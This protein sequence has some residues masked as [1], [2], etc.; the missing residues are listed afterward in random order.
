[1]IIINSLIEQKL[2]K[3]NMMGIEVIGYNDWGI[4]IRDGQKYILYNVYNNSSY[5]AECRN[6]QG[7]APVIHSHFIILYNMVPFK[8]SN[9][10]RMEKKPALFTKYTSKDLLQR[11]SIL[12]SLRELR[13]PTYELI[14][15]RNPDFKSKTIIN[16]K[17]KKLRITDQS[18]F[19]YS[20]G[21]LIRALDGKYYY[22]D[23]YGSASVPKGY[24]IAI[25]EVD[26]E[27]RY[28]KRINNE[29]IQFY[30]K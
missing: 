16:Y 3:L 13:N 26:K 20:N 19:G 4:V 23:G 29:C 12:S 24:G 7:T 10:T 14:E 2:S 30:N 11:N 15:L 27:L 21:M 28:V 1:M 22:F 18:L 5:A 6:T 17:G 8:S 25:S 9:G